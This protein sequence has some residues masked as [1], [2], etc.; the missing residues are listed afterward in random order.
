MGWA[1]YYEDNI[2]ICNDRLFMATVP[3]KICCEPLKYDPVKKRKAEKNKP[4][5]RQQIACACDQQIRTGRKAVQRGMDRS[6]LGNMYP[7]DM[8]EQYVSE[9]GVQRKRAGGHPDD[10]RG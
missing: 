4:V 7:E 5:A 6:D 8:A 1:K 2:S 9:Y 3:K 10:D